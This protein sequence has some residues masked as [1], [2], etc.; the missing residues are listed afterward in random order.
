VAISAPKRICVV[1]ASTVVIR[2]IGFTRPLPSHNT[3]SFAASHIVIVNNV[4]D[5]FVW[6]SMRLP[7]DIRAETICFWRRV[8]FVGCVHG[9]LNASEENGR[10]RDTIG[11]QRGSTSR[12]ENFL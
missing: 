10:S 11:P 6:L 1:R 7:T 8:L 9:H 5:W 3:L 2:V 4:R 12:R